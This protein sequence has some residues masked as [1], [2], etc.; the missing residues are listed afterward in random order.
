MA[1]IKIKNVTKRFKDKIVLDN[2]SFEVEE[3]EVFGFIGPNES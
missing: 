1:I 3:G 2:I